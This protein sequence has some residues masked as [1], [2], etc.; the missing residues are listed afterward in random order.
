M[1]DLLEDIGL[2]V[3]DLDGTLVDSVPDL[4]AAVDAALLEAA[5]PMAGEDKVRRWVGNG[6]RVLIER[7]LTDALGEAPGEVFADTTH[8]QFLSYYAEHPCVQTRLYPGAIEAIKGFWV[9]GIPL[10]IVTNKPEAFV[11]PILETTGINGYFEGWLG[12]DSLPR[13]KPDPMPLLYACERFDVAPACSMM[14]GDSRHD[15]AAGKAAGFVTVAVPYGYN[16]GEPVSSSEPDLLV[17]S[18]AQLV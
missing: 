9:R 12:G 13:R 7:A 8:E 6:S 11:G 16:H 10:F 15:V 18:L 1:R 5:L 14:I 4:T 3:F 2:V 17:E